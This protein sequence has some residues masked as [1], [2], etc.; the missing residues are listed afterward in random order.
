[1]LVLLLRLKVVLFLGAAVAVHVV[2]LVV[3]NATVAIVVVENTAAFILYLAL[4]RFK[5]RLF[6]VALK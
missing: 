3:R 6:L 5:N 2:L 1:M 4:F